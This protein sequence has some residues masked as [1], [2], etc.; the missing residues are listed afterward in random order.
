MRGW[1]SVAASGA[2]YLCL[3]GPLKCLHHHK[4]V[5]NAPLPSPQPLAIN[6]GNAEHSGG[7]CQ[8]CLW[9]STARPAVPGEH[10][11]QPV[12]P[13][14][15]KAEG[16][17]CNTSLSQ[18]IPVPNSSLSIIWW[19]IINRLPLQFWSRNFLWINVG[20]VL[21]FFLPS[22]CKAVAWN[23]HMSLQEPLQTLDVWLLRVIL[24]LLVENPTLRL[25]FAFPRAACAGNAPLRNDQQ[26]FLCS[27][28]DSLFTTYA[29][30][31]FF[32]PQCKHSWSLYILCIL[33]LNMNEVRQPCS[34]HPDQGLK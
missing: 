1:W 13:Y 10:K 32:C 8:K 24:G 31:L 22:P 27:A 21:F 12:L 18:A 6:P 33:F 25:S 19:F 11:F 15:M 3:P 23:L 4:E 9:S 26:Q 2:T 17:K 20:L 29:K 16:E 7:L 28:P 14:T 30:G 5:R 34:R